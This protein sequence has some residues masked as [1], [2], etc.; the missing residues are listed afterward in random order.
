MKQLNKKQPTFCKNCLVNAYKNVTG[1]IIEEDRDL[2]FCISRTQTLENETIERL[3]KLNSII[4]ES[5][6]LV[7]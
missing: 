6:N 7:G 2:C 4:E 5:N 3:H 1:E